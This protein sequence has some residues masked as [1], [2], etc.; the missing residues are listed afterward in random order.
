MNNLRRY[1]KFVALP[2]IALMIAATMPMGVV[3]AALVGTDQVIAPT[4]TEIDRARVAAFLA[5]EYTSGDDGAE[6]ANSMHL[7][8]VVRDG[9]SAHVELFDETD[10]AAATARAAELRQSR[11]VPGTLRHSQ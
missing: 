7:V 6:F 5:R 1:T 2:L 10:S 9:Q 8:W 11:N 4:Q 3:Q